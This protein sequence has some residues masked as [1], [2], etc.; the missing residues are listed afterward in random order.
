VLESEPNY[1]LGM[2]FLGRALVA[3]GEYEEGVR[4]LR[5]A[6]DVLGHISFSRGDLGYGLAKSGQRGEAE[7]LRADLMQRRTRGYFPAF[8]IAVIE[9]GLGNTEAAMD[10]LEQAADERNLGFYLPSADPNYD[11]VRSH[12]RFKAVMK[13]AN[14]DGLARR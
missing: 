1:G 4:Q 12:P 10:W 9:L 13:R 2:H 5:R 3:K 14:L 11:A 7:A 6:D 8:P